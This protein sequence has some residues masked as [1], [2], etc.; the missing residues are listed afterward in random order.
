M[1][2]AALVATFVAGPGELAGALTWPLILTG[3]GLA[4]LHPVLPFSLEFLALRG[5]TT[6]AFGTLMSLEPAIALAV[7]LVA[8]GQ[9]PGAASAVGVV[10]VVIAGI[11][12]IRT[13]R[14]DTAPAP[15]SGSGS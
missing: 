1:P 10:C 2:V 4:V 12:A 11:G 14:R 6:T 15:G 9:V 8:L 3:L 13:G 7:G 5:L